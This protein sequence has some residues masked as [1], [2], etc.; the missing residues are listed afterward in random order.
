MHRVGF[1]SPE[2]LHEGG[3]IIAG[4]DRL[5]GRTWDPRPLARWEAL[6]DDSLLRQSGHAAVLRRA[7]IHIDGK[8]NCW[9][10]GLFR[11]RE[12]LFASTFVAAGCSRR[13]QTTKSV[14]VEPLTVGV[15]ADGLV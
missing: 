10:I 8:E 3:S 2:L 5:L 15:L 13:R 9:Q 1:T 11:Q 4:L 12:V 7:E 6:L 14:I